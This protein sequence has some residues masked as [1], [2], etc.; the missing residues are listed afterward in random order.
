[1]QNSFS[2]FIAQVKVNNHKNCY[3]AF[4]LYLGIAVSSKLCFVELGKLL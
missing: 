4:I 3:K 1:M 2:G